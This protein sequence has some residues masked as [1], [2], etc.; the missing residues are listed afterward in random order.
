MMS[1]KLGFGDYDSPVGMKVKTAT[2]PDLPRDGDF[3]RSMEVVDAVNKNS[4]GVNQL[5]KALVKQV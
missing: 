4:D 3:T 1:D 5:E 2:T